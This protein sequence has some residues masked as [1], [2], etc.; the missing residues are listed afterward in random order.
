MLVPWPTIS[1]SSSDTASIYP[2][3]FSV[4]VKILSFIRIGRNCNGSHTPGKQVD[5]LQDLTYQNSFILVG[6]STSGRFLRFPEQITHCAKIC[7]MSWRSGGVP[8][9]HWTLGRDFFD[10]LDK[11]CACPRYS[12]RSSSPCL[13]CYLISHLIS[14][15]IVS[16]V[17]DGNC[18]QRVE[19][20]P[21]LW[22]KTRLKSTVGWTHWPMH[23]M[24]HVR[25]AK[26]VPGYRPD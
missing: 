6:Y 23:R 16:L 4:A 10:P 15:L 19:L 5:S 12:D 18:K 24:I 7:K 14:A 21:R 22:T 25:T 26:N 3:A 11:L 1:Q 20:Y 8:T 2:S 9:S 17:D 13:V